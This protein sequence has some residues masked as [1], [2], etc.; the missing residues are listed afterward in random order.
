MLCCASFFV[1]G[2]FAETEGLVIRNRIECRFEEYLGKSA[3]K[4]AV[5]ANYILHQQKPRCV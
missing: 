2:N 1:E 5:V 4:N 3:R